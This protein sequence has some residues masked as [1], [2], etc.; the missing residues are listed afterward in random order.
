MSLTGTPTF[1]EQPNPDLDKVID[2]RKISKD[3]DQEGR[4]KLA[5]EI[6]NLRKTDQ[7]LAKDL[8]TGIEILGGLTDERQQSTEQLIENNQSLIQEGNKPVS[9]LRKK[10]GLPPNKRMAQLENSI[11]QLDETLR[12]QYIQEAQLTQSQSE[13]EAQRSSLPN[14]RELIDSYYERMESLPLTNQEKRELLTPE[15]LSE[16]NDEEYIALWRRL[17]PQF[18]SHVTRQGFRDHTGND[19]M[20]DHS[21]GYREF[22]NG[23]LN[24]ME[25]GRTLLP[26][27]SRIGLVGRDDKTV[28]QFIEGFFSESQG[29]SADEAKERFKKFLDFSHASAPKYAD[30]TATHFA[31]QIVSD[32]YYGGESDNEVMFIYPSDVIASQYAYGFNGWEKDFTKPQSETKWN[33][34][35]IWTDPNNPGVPV[36]SGI[37]FLPENTPVDPETGSKYA[38]EVIQD[39]EGKETRVMIKDDGLHDRFIQWGGDI[40]ESIMDLVRDY[41]EERHYYTQQ[42]KED[43]VLYVLSN[44]FVE[45]GFPE[46]VVKRLAYEVLGDLLYL[47]KLPEGNAVDLLEKTS[48]HFVR[49]KNAIPAK[50]YWERLFKENPERRP[51]HVHYYGGRPTG[52][53]FDFLVE[54]K[55]GNADTSGEEGLL[56][57]FDDNHVLEMDTD[58]RANSGYDDLIEQA[59]LIIE[60]L[61]S[62]S[63]NTNAE[64]RSRTS[65]SEETGS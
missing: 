11:A 57:G 37:V 65:T 23:F 26:P 34:V 33:D 15:A 61:Y 49:A 50:E 25:N 38:S 20:V 52:A 56:L 47:D 27:L 24:V 43:E 46:D 10:L 29:I 14:A 18:L 22:E 63:D 64:E 62:N 7:G 8:V 36:D 2:P 35:F 3:N 48:A 9:R 39:E 31:A 19:V 53:V 30:I 13:I 6:W 60:E 1:T 58:P 21:S 28:R 4:D 32:A 17:N 12:T 41:K 40:E 16:L 54:K 51:K 45:L 59:N 55:I 42:R 44:R 5:S